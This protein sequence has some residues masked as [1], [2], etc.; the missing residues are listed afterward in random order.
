MYVF[1]DRVAW[2]RGPGCLA[3]AEA[4]SDSEPIAMSDDLRRSCIANRVEYLVTKK[5]TSFDL[6]SAIVPHEVDLSSIDAVTAAVADGPHSPLAVDV[7]IQISAKLGIPASVATAYHTNEDRSVAEDRLDHLTAEVDHPVEH[8][9]VASDTASTI[10]ESL[11][12]STLLVMGAPGGSWFHRQL[13]GPGHKLV[14]AAPA[15]AVLV[16]S[17][18]RRAFMDAEDPTSTA[19]G[20]HLAVVD[21]KRVLVDPVAPVVDEGK[22]VGI[23]RKSKLE[24]AEHDALLGDVMDPPVF[25][26]AGEPVENASELSSFLEGSPIPVVDDSHR[27]V[28]VLRPD[29][30][31][32]G[33]HG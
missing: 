2:T 27:L 24:N 29:V 20:R 16:R 14:V 15:G 11:S 12:S 1:S 23:V 10:V 31:E 19:L 9:A 13:F 3:L 25:V 18:S 7:A 21:A 17:V 8:V 30:G 26:D 28:G 5:L 22:L 4:L 33:P 32:S 6:V